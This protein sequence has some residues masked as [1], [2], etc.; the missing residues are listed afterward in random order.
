[1]YNGGMGSC[2]TYLQSSAMFRASLCDGGVELSVKADQGSDANV[3]PQKIFTDIT[4]APSSLQI[5]KLSGQIQCGTIVKKGP[6]VTFHSQASVPVLLHIRH[7]TMLALRIVQWLICNEDADYVISGE[8]VLRALG[9]DSRRLPE[10]AADRHGSSIDVSELT[11]KTL[12]EDKSQNRGAGTVQSLMETVRAQTG[13]T[14]HCDG[15]AEEDHLE[16]GDM[17]VDL[18]EDLAEELQ[19]EISK[20]VD[21]AWSKGIS[22]Q[23]A[24]RLSELLKKYQEFL[25]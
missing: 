16:R 21:E 20:R 10:A 11:E 6:K 1:M 17:Y 9:L 18:G 4:K 7:G 5:K 14:Y 23:G 19:T 2:D 22:E 13:C 12:E 3:I 24:T 25:E 15:A 8:T